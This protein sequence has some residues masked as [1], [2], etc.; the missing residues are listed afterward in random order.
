MRRTAPKRANRSQVG[1]S[2]YKD[3]AIQP[4]DFICANQLG[5]LE[6]CIIKYVTRWRRKGGVEDLR[7]A[8]H[9]LEK[10]MEEE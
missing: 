6:G 9:C 7:K 4:W 5:Y 8:R 1:G 10:L 3:L 2:H